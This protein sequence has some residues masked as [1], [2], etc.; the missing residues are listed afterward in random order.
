MFF[1]CFLNRTCTPNY[2]LLLYLHHRCQEWEVVVGMVRHHKWAVCQECLPCH[3]LECHRWEATKTPTYVLISACGK[4]YQKRIV[5]LN[6][7]GRCSS[8]MSDQNLSVGI[9]WIITY[10]RCNIL[11][12][13]GE[14]FFLLFV[15]S[16]FFFGGDWR[17]YIYTRVSH[18]TRMS[19]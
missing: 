4:S 2:C 11:W 7:L 17:V 14:S 9:M 10:F 3:H 6:L 1:F 12:W 18:F 19:L 8:A 13:L 16:H 5:R 15:E